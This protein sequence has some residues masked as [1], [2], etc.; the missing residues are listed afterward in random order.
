MSVA[1]ATTRIRT[2]PDPDNPLTHERREDTVVP[3]HRLTRIMLGV[4]NV[5]D[6]A[7]YYTQFGRTSAATDISSIYGAEAPA[8]TQPSFLAPED[9]AALMTGA[10]R[11]Q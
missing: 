1:S 11:G 6:T 8:P 4:P 5:E 7:A 10:H 3:L 2:D 9:L